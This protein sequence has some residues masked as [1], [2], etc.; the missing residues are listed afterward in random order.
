LRAGRVPLRYR[1]LH[2]VVPPGRTR[3]SSRG[4]A[5]RQGHPLSRAQ[6]RRAVARRLAGTLAL[7]AACLAWLA[8]G[9][10]GGPGRALAQAGLAPDSAALAESTR[11]DSVQKA[12]DDSVAVA[13]SLEALG[14]EEEAY[15]GN[16][17]RLLGGTP[18]DHPL[19]YSTSYSTLR[20][21]RTWDQG[22]DLFGKRRGLAAAAR[23]NVTILQDPDVK[24]NTRNRSAMFE[25]GY[26]VVPGLTSGVHVGVSRNSDI[27]GIRL[28][29]SIVR[30][31]DEFTAFTRFNRQLLGLPIAANAS[32]GGVRDRQ[33][34]FSRQGR[35]LALDANTRGHLLHTLEWNVNGN[36]RKDNMRSS[37]PSDT[38]EFTSNDRTTDR[39]GAGGVTWVPFRWLSMD[40]KGMVRRG[41]LQRPEQV[42]DPETFAQVVVQEEVTT[43]NNSGDAGFLLTTPIGTVLT[44]RGNVNDTEILYGADSTRNNV[45]LTRGFTVSAQDTLLG[46][47]VSA[48]FQNG[49]TDND[50]TKRADGYRQLQWR[51]QADLTALRRLNRRTNSQL[52]G[53]VSLESR[54]YT[55]FRPSSPSSFPPSS[56][57]LFRALGSMRVDYTPLLT[58]STGVEGQIDLNR[59]I[60]LASTSSIGNTDQVGYQVTWRWSFTPWWFWTIGQVNSAGAQDINN[61]FAPDRDQLSFIYQINTSNSVSLTP[62]WRLD[63]QYGLRYQSRGTYLQQEGGSRSFGKSGGADEYDLTLRTSYQLFKWLSCDVT[64][65]RFVTQNYSLPEAVRRVDSRTYRRNL[66][67]NLNASYP[68]RSGGSLSLALRRSLTWDAQDRNTI[69]P[70][71][72]TETNDDYWQATMSFRTYWGGGGVK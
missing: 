72:R 59:T 12:Y 69:P 39:S 10:V 18:P 20:N 48:T 71:P 27:I 60:N 31:N 58:L 63:M 17:S 3:P 44:V 40:A 53:S 4:R 65:Q 19:N 7:A 25:L 5:A 26:T 32:F 34:E 43:N 41:I 49:T 21:R 64:G 56:Q 6:G 24:R 33:P 37:A 45:A 66:L 1:R 14:L 57:D 51:R 35:T 8:A 70:T 50:Y 67:A 38:G 30:D 22:L 42:L 36:Y 52:R 15:S 13:D 29:N 11:A 55:D 61:P 9:R 2:A 62:R 68:F 47:S 23:L 16:A 28:Q 54:R 46:A